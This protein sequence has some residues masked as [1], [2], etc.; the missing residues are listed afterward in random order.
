[1]ISPWCMT[2]TLSDSA[3]TARMTCSIS[4]MVMPRTALRS[5]STCTIRSTSVGRRPAIT[6]SS[7][8]RRGPVAS[9]RATSSRLRS[10]S[11]S[12]AAGWPRLA[13][14]PSRSSTSSAR[15]TRLADAAAGV[16]GADHHVVEHGEACERLDQL[17][18]AADAGAAD[19]VRPPAVD[20]PAVE[21]HEPR[22]G[23]VDAGDH[24]EAGGLAGA[25][26][27]DQRHDLALADRKG[28]VLG[29]A[30][31]LEALRQPLDLKQRRHVTRPACRTAWCRGRARG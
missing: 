27:A 7:S 28:E 15:P 12:E 17:E 18:G 30:Q 13:A 20:A 11:V 29:G 23:P 9:A 3:I 2:I 31:P 26:G 10:G 8:R 22:I 19:L 1:M 6:S 5:R 24:V 4:R 21:A 14:R 16:E 25:V